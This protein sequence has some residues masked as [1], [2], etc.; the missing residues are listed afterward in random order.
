M[1]QKIFDERTKI[2]YTLVGD[3][4]LPDLKVSDTNF[5]IG[6]WGKLNNK[7]LKENHPT[8]RHTMLM[9]GTLNE[10]LHNIDVQAEEQYDRTM[11]QLKK[12]QGI[13]E[14]LKAKNQLAWV[15]AMNNITHQATEIILNEIV[16][17]EAVL[18]K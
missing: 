4:Y 17:N 11:E 13:T 14:E 6:K 9:N 15:Q 1:K 7:W 12:Q 18:R 5:E 16:Y 8:V 2:S 10:Y 3:V